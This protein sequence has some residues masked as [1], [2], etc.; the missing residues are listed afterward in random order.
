MQAWPLQIEAKQHPQLPASA[1]NSDSFF[2]FACNRILQQ[3]YQGYITPGSEEEKEEE[4]EVED[5]KE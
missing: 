4:D 2:F 5:K 1:Y 3:I